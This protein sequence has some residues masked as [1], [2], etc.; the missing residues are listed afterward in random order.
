[1]PEGTLRWGKKLLHV[2]GLENGCHALT[3]ADGTRVETGLLVGADGAWSRVRPM[4][5]DLEPS[6]VGTVYVE[7]YLYDVEK[8]HAGLAKLIGGGAMYALT[9]GKGI[10]AHREAGDIIHTYVEMSRSPEWVASIDFS[11]RESAA[12]RIKAEFRGGRLSLRL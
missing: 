1:M 5:S 2:E 9:P 11:D 6:Y 4:L 10:V 7:T 3:F 8:Q 12:A